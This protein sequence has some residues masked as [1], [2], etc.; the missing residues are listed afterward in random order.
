MQQEQQEV[1]WML[2]ALLTF[3]LG[4]ALTMSAMGTWLA[5]HL[6][7][8]LKQRNKAM[9]SYVRDILAVVLIPMSINAFTYGYQFV[10]ALVFMI[11]IYTYFFWFDYALNHQPKVLQK[12]EKSKIILLIIFAIF[13]IIGA[14]VIIIF[15]C[16][17]LMALF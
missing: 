8:D 5:K 13:A 11:A 6:S 15:L 7:F 9:V 16:K 2:F 12:L 4:I 3:I 14:L 10:M 17:C 1:L